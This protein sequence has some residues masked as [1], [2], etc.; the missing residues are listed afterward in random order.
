MKYA[1]VIRRK[2]SPRFSIVYW[3]PTR[4]RRIFETTPFLVDDPQGRRKALALA[5]EKSKAAVADKDVGGADRWERWVEDFLRERYKGRA[6]TLQ[7]MLGAWEQ[8]ARFCAEEAL[9]VPRALDYN[10]VL[11]FIAWRR[12]QVK[13]SGKHVSKNTAL[14]DVRVM[15]VIMREGLRASRFCFSTT[16]SRGYGRA[17]FQ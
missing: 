3:C 13:P 10:S 15:S 6:K 4:Q 1:S 5:Y 9:R 7:R 12:A 16:A 8:W 14:C 17:M 11:R 2:R